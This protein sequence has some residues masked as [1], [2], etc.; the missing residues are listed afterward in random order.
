MKNEICENCE[1]KIVIIN[2]HQQTWKFE[3]IDFCS[4]NCAIVWCVKKILE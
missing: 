1:R 2:S 3:D 4:S